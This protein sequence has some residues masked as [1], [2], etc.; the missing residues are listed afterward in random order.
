MLRVGL[1]GGLGSGK[2]TVAGLFRRFGGYVIEADELG[3]QLME[4]GESV[5]LA[6][7][8]HFGVGVVRAD[9]RLNRPELARLAFADGRLDELNALVH[10]AVIVAQQRW[11]DGLFA[12]DPLA[13]GVVESAIL[14]EVER[15]AA[16]RGE[17]DGPMANW[18]SRFDRVVVVRT[19]DEAKIARYLRRIDPERKFD[20]GQRAAAEADA[21]RRLQHQIP[22]EEKARMADYVINNNGTLEELE[23]ASREVFTKL[24]AE[25]NTANN[26]GLLK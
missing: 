22:D 11:L 18:R 6:I 5:Y 9:G 15:D 23:A 4:P 3:R 19:P 26:G 17:V 13:V 2:S 12:G 8:E 7:V 16:R 25:S 14:F 1:T 10:P 21:R 20:D 24:A